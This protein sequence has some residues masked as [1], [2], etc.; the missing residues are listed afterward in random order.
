MPGGDRTG[1]NGLG[2]GTGRNLGYCVDNTHTGA[3]NESYEDNRRFGFGRRNAHRGGRGFGPGRGLGFRHGFS[4]FYQNRMG[5]LN[6][7]TLIENAINSLKDQLERLE[8]RLKAIR[9]E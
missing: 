6:E 2:A 8:I 7:K 1:P 4:S 5:E 9:D 3:G